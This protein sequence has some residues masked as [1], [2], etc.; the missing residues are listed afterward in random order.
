MPNL[1]VTWEKESP[2]VSVS[3]NKEEVNIASV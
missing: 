1:G 2:N 3:M